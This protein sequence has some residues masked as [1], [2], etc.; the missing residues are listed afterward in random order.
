MLQMSS[1]Y[2]SDWRQG[3]IEGFSG[4]AFGPMMATFY[5]AAGDRRSALS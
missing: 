2:S 3:G 5:R 4:N 1:P